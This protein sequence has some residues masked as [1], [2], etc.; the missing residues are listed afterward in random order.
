MALI[1]LSLVAPTTAPAAT[2][3]PTALTPELATLATPAVAAE[4]PAAQ[5]EAIGLPAEGP[6]SLIREGERVVVEAHFEAGAL[7]QVE[8]LEAAGAEILTTS[9]TYQTIALSVEPEDLEALAE[10]PGLRVV[11]PSRSPVFYGIEGSPS[12]AVTAPNCEG[13]SV[14]SQGVAQLNV[15]AARAAFGLRGAGQTIGVI[16][17]SFNSATESIEGG[18]IATKAA[19]DEVS[20][21][22]PGPASS[23]VGQQVPVR[24]IAEVPVSPEIEPTDEG[25]AMLQVIHDV[26]PEAQLAFATAYSSELEFAQNIERLAAPVAVGGAGATVIVDDVAYQSEPFF[27]D[28]PV[29]VAIQNVTAAGVTYL[30]AAGNDNL[31]EAKTNEIASWEAPAFRPMSCPSEIAG[32][33]F[34][35]PSRCMDFDPGTDGSDVDSTF[36]ITVSGHELLTVDLQWAEP[37]Y[38]VE[39]DLNA[40]LLNEAEEIIV[41]K[42]LVNYKSGAVP[43]P[44]EVLQWENKSGGSK[45]VQ[46]VI[47]RCSGLCNLTKASSTATPRLKFILAEDG[48]GVTS[49]E[50]PRSEGGDIVGPTVYGHAGSGAAITLGAVAYT[51]SAIAPKEPE[52]YSSR[53]PVTHYFGPVTSIT[54]AAELAAPE[55]LRKPNLT[56]TD[57]ASTTFFAQKQAGVYHFCGTSEAAPHA[58]AVAALMRQFNPVASPAAINAAMEASA[59]KY[60]AVTSPAAV[61]AGLLNA[62]AAISTLGPPPPPPPAPEPTPPTPE[63]KITK[64][65]K[66][67]SN[68]TRPTFEFSSSVSASFSCQMN[69]GAAQSCSSPYTVPSALGDGSHGFNVTATAQG[70]SG[71]SA[72]GFKV[73][74]K[75]PKVKIAGHPGKVV[76]TKKRRVVARFKLTA[77]GG[78]V[79]F[80]CKV[81]REARRVCGKKFRHRFKRGKHELKVWA[82]DAAGNSSAKAVVFRFQVKALRR[83]RSPR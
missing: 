19:N 3:E 67:I 38:G 59:T 34:K 27:Q 26:A 40:Y 45:N 74:T 2:P 30:T 8:A 54:P 18:P 71:S 60:T 12:T 55:A 24:V 52:R 49:T 28:G 36:G 41:N 63:V 43:F 33:G 70:R 31:I 6:G 11:T 62:A 64:G 77:S 5:A 53:G 66:A 15:P 51:E 69:G 4:P 16:S 68:Q 23:C 57:C 7:S 80:S 29:A 13:G 56:A 75:A 22:L 81:D 14:I 50:Y 58:A 61:G 10:V 46:L 79:T 44:V 32:L 42:P 48:Q 82:R 1:A 21:D 39:T 35:A 17:D 78:P 65:P 76:R 9:S 20:N 25:R 83:A 72:Y 37:W 73:D 47:G